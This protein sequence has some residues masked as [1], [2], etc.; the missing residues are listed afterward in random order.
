M[1]DSVTPRE[2]ID[3]FLAG[4][5]VDRPPCVPLIL[6]HAARLIGA[7]I[8]SYGT[9]GAVMGA[10]HVAAY[11]RYGQDLI[12]I[13][14]DTSVTG[15]ALGSELYF[16]DDDVSRLKTPAVVEP[17]DADSLVV[18]DVT[19]AGR[20]PVLLEAIRH[21]V[22]EVG[23]EV[24]VSC[25]IPAPFSTAAAVRSTAMLAR[26]LYKRPELA[27]K[28]LDI[29]TRLVIDFC[30]AVA[31]A[32]GIPALVDP[33]A[34]GSVLSR[35][36]FEEFALPGLKAVLGEIRKMGFPTILHICGRTSGIIDLMAD[37]GAMVLSIDEIELSEAKEKVGERVCL[38]GNVSPTAMILE[39]TPEMVQSA[40]RKCFEDA[41]DSPGGFILA[42][43]CEVPI[44]APPENVQALIETAREYRTS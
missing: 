5:P 10:S 12:T 40:A 37:A 30:K 3:A 28:L 39:G 43:G 2:R 29:S 14:T 6:N 42:T 36:F 9:D 4:K 26:D 11:R 1:S 21:S 27:R 24:Y 18:P 16:P 33:V 35:K 44:E 41:G 22:R 38:M 31:A 15:E 8:K 25:C 19:T 13:F 20:L 23:E 7:S 32:G 17:E 34:S